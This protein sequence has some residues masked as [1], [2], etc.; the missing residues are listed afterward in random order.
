MGFTSIPGCLETDFLGRSMRMYAENGLADEIAFRSCIYHI[1]MGSG[2]NVFFQKWLK[3]V[4]E[5][6]P[7]TYS[8][9]LARTAGFGVKL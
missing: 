2:R 7:A 4:C 8:L 1:Y 3:V 9:L 6:G 5:W